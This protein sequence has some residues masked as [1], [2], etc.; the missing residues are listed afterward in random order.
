MDIVVWGRASWGAGHLRDVASQFAFGP[1]VVRASE[2]FATTKL[3]YAFVN[4]KPLVP[5]LFQSGQLFVKQAYQ[6]FLLAQGLDQDVTPNTPMGPRSGACVLNPRCRVQS[7]PMQP[8]MNGPSMSQLSLQVLFGECEL[9]Q[10]F[11]AAALTMSQ[12]KA[13][14]ENM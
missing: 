4:L 5:G 12:W 10:S 2:V 1:H 7:N 9:P 8:Q 6:G 11:M 14:K 3:S 13:N